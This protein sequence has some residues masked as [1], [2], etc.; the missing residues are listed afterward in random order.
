MTFPVPT[1]R[2]AAVVAALGGGAASWSTERVRFCVLEAL[3]VLV[4]LVDLAL[5]VSPRRIEVDRE[6]PGVGRARLPLD[7]V[8]DR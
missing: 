4:A 5:A 3:I 2:L 1:R 6:L 7:L 8:V